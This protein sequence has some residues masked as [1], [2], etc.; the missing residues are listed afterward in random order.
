[1]E[2]LDFKPLL[3]QISAMSGKCKRFARPEESAEVDQAAAEMRSSL[4]RFTVA[5][6]RLFA[7]AR[8]IEARLS[9]GE[10]ELSDVITSGPVS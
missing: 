9:K 8:G 10:P 6:G 5:K 2:E 1:M 7:I 4:D 3:D